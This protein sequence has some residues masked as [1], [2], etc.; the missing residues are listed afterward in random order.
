MLGEVSLVCEKCGGFLEGYS[1]GV[2][3]DY[4]CVVTE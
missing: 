1:F 4:D 3:V 2:V